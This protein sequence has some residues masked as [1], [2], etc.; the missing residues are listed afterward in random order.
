MCLRL[1]CTPSTQ[2]G[3]SCGPTT[4]EEARRARLGEAKAVTG[5]KRREKGWSRG[6]PDGSGARPGGHGCDGD[7]VA[8]LWRAVRPGRAPEAEQ[9]SAE[10]RKGLGGARACGGKERRRQPQSSGSVFCLGHGG[11]TQPAPCPRSERERER[12]ARAEEDKGEGGEQRSVPTH[13]AADAQRGSEHGTLQHKGDG[14]T[15]RTTEA[16]SVPMWA[17]LA[18]CTDTSEKIRSPVL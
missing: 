14:G 4:G 7:K 18:P 17:T 8:L 15:G 3:G 13:G 5:A 10:L 16:Q 11:T 9:V 2:T 1:G 6:R 12:A